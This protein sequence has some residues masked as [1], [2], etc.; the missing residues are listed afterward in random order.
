MQQ[1]IID[2]SKWRTGG[3]ISDPERLNKYGNTLLLNRQGYMCC[4]GFY[5][6]QLGGIPKD[7]LLG[8]S[9]PEAL[10][11]DDLGL[12]DINIITKLVIKKDHYDVEDDYTLLPT[13]FTSDAIEINDSPYIFSEERENQIVD[14][15][16]NHNVEVIFKNKYE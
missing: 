12:D 7:K 13:S 2:R 4:L 9:S 8:I 10:G 14:H 15:F 11:L 6:E 1:L 16:K 5:C 3:S